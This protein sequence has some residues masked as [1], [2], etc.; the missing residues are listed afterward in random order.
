MLPN[1]QGIWQGAEKKIKIMPEILG[2]IIR[3]KY[4]DNAEKNA[5]LCRNL[6]N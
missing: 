3:E 6:S 5:G 4:V 1:Y 2:S